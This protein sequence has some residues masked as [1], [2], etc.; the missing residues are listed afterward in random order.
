[1]QAFNAHLGDAVRLSLIE[2]AVR[3]GGWP[4]RCTNGGPTGSGKQEEERS[5]MPVALYNTKGK[6]LTIIAQNGENIDDAK[7]ELVVTWPDGQVITFCEC[8]TAHRGLADAVECETAGAEVLCMSTERLNDPQK[9]PSREPGERRRG[10]QRRARS[11]G[12]NKE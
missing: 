8:K 7:A 11:R 3:D 5:K 2:S 12:G 9:K 4:P 10:Q 6:L 1:M